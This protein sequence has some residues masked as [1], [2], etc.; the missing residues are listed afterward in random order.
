VKLSSHWIALAALVAASIPAGV[1]ETQAAG[2]PYVIYLSN[3]FVGNDWRQQMLRIANV[4]VTKPPLLGNVDLKVEVVDNTTEAQINSLNNIIRQKPDAILVD[5]A[6]DTALNPTL[7]K[8]CD[9]GIVVVSFD[10]V[11]TLPCAYKLES[12]WDVQPAVQAEWIAEMIHGKGNVLMDRGLAGA[13]ISTQLE[14]GFENVLKKYPDIKIVGYFNGNYALGPEQQGVAAL[15]AANPQVDAI[16]TQGYGSGAMKAL[17][18]AG[19]PLVPV[20]GGAYNVASLA[21]ANTPGAKCILESNPAYLSA[22][23]MKLAVA[24]LDGNPPTEKHI[25]LHGPFLSTDPMPSKLFPDIKM[26][27]IVVGQNAFPD[28]APGLALPITPDWVSISAQ[29]AAGPAK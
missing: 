27:K 8:A 18:D 20:A 28:L 25:Y 3:N 19:R 16:L 10:Q 14:T 17:E 4:A 22:E 1:V 23:A 7:Q 11:V 5:A 12:N 29:E 15:L 6:S 26:D 9:A 2:K 13:P 21:C 24:V